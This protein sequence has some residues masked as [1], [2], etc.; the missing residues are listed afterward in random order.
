MDT[1]KRSRSIEFYHSNQKYYI[2]RIHIYIYSYVRLMWIATFILVEK[3]CRFMVTE[4]VKL[5]DEFDTRC[6]SKTNMEQFGSFLLQCALNC[7]N[8]KVWHLH[9]NK[10]RDVTI[11]TWFIHK[12]WSKFVMSRDRNGPCCRLKSIREFCK[13]DSQV[14][15]MYF[16]LSLSFNFNVPK[17]EKATGYSWIIYIVLYFAVK[18]VGLKMVDP[19]GRSIRKYS[20]SV[21][22]SYKNI[23][24]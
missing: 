20:I 10:A 13:K 14:I 23:C 24:S 22:S 21:F 9:N 15:M 11:M 7:T 18:K 17:P 16:M 5:S 12:R 1:I 3:I 2:Y 19:E 4:F 8:A 6:G